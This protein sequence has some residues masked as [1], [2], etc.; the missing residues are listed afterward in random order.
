MANIYVVTRACNADTFLPLYFHSLDKAREYMTDTFVSEMKDI[1]NN[2]DI[3]FD[4]FPSGRTRITVTDRQLGIKS[5]VYWVV[6]ENWYQI[7]CARKSSVCHIDAIDE[8][9]FPKFE[10]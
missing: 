9:K 1:T 2:A 3:S 7:Q 5:T 10:D 6:E 4:K 8:D